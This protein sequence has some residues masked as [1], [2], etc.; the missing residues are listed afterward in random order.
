MTEQL[1]RGAWVGWSATRHGYT[2]TVYDEESREVHRYDAGNSP[3]D[4]GAHVP[5]D[6]KRPRVP[7]QTLRKWAR[8]TAQ[9]IAAEYGVNGGMIQQEESEED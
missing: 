5:L 6:S 2:V 3:D 8:Q 9:E 1:K 4:S 7:L